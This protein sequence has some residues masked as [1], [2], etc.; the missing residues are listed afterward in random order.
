MDMIYI[1]VGE[2]YYLRTL[3][4]C[5]CASSFVELKT[6]DGIEYLTFQ[7]AA[8]ARNIVDDQNECLRCMEENLVFSTP[9][10]LR[11]LFIIMTS[12]G[13]A[14]LPI[15]EHT[16]IVSGMTTDYRIRL[17][18]GN[19]IDER[20]MNLLYQDFQKRLATQGKTLSQVIFIITYTFIYI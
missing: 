19:R 14:T 11:S 8:Y 17:R 10:E 15:L 2:M 12:Q 5:V 6:F 13:F 18:M 16:A 7:E 9:H 4:L 3:L 20:I 1:N